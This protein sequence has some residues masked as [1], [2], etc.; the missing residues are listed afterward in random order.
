M[1]Y[2]WQCSCGR[3]VPIAVLE[4]RCGQPRDNIDVSP[5]AAT[6]TSHSKQHIRFRIGAL[7][8]CVAALA[9]VSAVYFRNSS[10]SGAE[11]ARQSSTVTVAAE[12][13]EQTPARDDTPLQE[14]PASPSLESRTALT[15]RETPVSL[16]PE[17]ADTR[18][19]AAIQHALRGVVTINTQTGSGTGF[20]VAPRL[21]ATNRHVV[22]NAYAVVVM[23]SRG[24]RLNGRVTVR[25]RAAD[26][27][28][29]T[30]DT[31]YEGVPL[32]LVDPGV[33]HVGEEVLAIGSPSALQLQ[34]TVT[35]GI[36]SAIRIVDGLN[37]I[38][39][40][41][42]LNPGNSG[43]PLLNM[44]GAVV[45]V[46]TWGVRNME[47]LGF[48][49]AAEHVRQLLA[50]GEVV[51]VVPNTAAAAMNSAVQTMPQE[52]SGIDTSRQ[53]GLQRFETAIRQLARQADEVDRRWAQYTSA[54]R[55]G[56][57]TNAVPYGRD[58][59][60]VWAT[61]AATNNEGLSECRS[62]LGDIVRVAI[63]IRSRMQ[64]AEEEARRASVYPGTRRDIRR[65]Y[66]MD[67]TGWDG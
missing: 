26:L 14:Q 23:T 61:P 44:S 35:R 15:Q 18:R 27:A 11:P 17:T 65:K 53:E 20:F 9:A 63:E 10:G 45:G 32:P 36:V 1:Q 19:E 29:V 62:L 48:A 33:V 22:E 5:K 42:A 66:A 34:G 37:Q 57:Q 64:A 56:R 49:I 7:L 60:G 38:Q 51:S 52:E 21:I 28:L 30:L 2:V 46:N 31:A 58:W 16:V 59:F 40:D 13:Q 8:A 41:A 25:A 6:E 12:P 55:G 3:R 47:S 24:E 67:W 43:G 54:C 50:A 39:T 4:C